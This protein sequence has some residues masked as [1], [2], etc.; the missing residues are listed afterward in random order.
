MN[1]AN[2]E[3]WVRVFLPA[4]SIFC[5]Y[6]LVNATQSGD[7]KQLK[8]D[9]AEAKKTAI[10]EDM[11]ATSHLGL[12][13]A[14]K[15]LENLQNEIDDVKDLLEQ[16]SSSLSSES[17]ADQLIV[18]DRIC[19]ELSIAVIKRGDA[20]NSK[21]GKLTRESTRELEDILPDGAVQYQQMELTGT[22]ASMVEFMQRLPKAVPGVIPLSV[23][24]VD[25]AS[26][27][28]AKVTL[29]SNERMWRVVFAI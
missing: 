24:L 5:L 3:K 11:L 7:M 21:L 8:A 26:G 28:T 29:R 22:Y 20:D 18:I 14:R 27:K 1:S 9:L 19:G 12:S 2:R 23:E 25:G 13:D 16:A 4:A 6:A 10:S 15:E 17:M